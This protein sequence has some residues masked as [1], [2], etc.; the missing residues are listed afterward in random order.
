[1]VVKGSVFRKAIVVFVI[2][3]MIS[4]GF[5]TSHPDYQNKVKLK[6]PNHQ[7]SETNYTVR[8]PFFIENDNETKQAGQVKANHSRPGK[9]NVDIDKTNR[10]TQR[11]F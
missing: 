3:V 10:L 11:L 4:P 8:S 6:K 2:A 9:S 7:L 5:T 1:M